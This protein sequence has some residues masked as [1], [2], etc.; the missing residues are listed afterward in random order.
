[1]LSDKG[2]SQEYQRQLAGSP[3]AAEEEAQEPSSPASPASSPAS[4]S[5]P[6]PCN[7]FG[8]PGPHTH[9]IH[10]TSRSPQQVSHWGFKV[11]SVNMLLLL[12]RHV[13]R[14][15][16]HTVCPTSRSTQSGQRALSLAFGE[17][18]GSDACLMVQL[19]AR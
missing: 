16:H 5:Y 8:V 13:G 1:M 19:V 17:S 18:G 3:D 15:S 6:M 12:T 9:P 14:H 10:T 4:R 7:G 11:Q 2:K